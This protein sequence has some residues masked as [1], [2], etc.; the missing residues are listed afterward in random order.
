MMNIITYR[1][2]FWSI[3]ILLELFNFIYYL[4]FDFLT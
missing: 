2:Y 3:Q 1:I 4:Y